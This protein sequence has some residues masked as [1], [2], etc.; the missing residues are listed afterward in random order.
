MPLEWNQV[1]KGLNPE[2]FSIA[3]VTRV[4]KEPWTDLLTKK[5]KLEEK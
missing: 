4:E 1:K 5:Q 2:D 3:N